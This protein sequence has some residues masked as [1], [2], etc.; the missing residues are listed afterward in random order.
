MFPWIVA[1][2]G[3]TNIRFGLVTAKDPETEEYEIL[4]LRDYVTAD[5]DS[6]AACLD[7]YLS[8]IRLSGGSNNRPQ[9]A[10]IAVAGPVDSDH[11]QLTNVDWSFSIAETRAQFS[12]NRLEVINDFTALACSVP[13]LNAKDCWQICPGEPREKA[14]KAIVGP[15]TGLG[16][17]ALVDNGNG[18]SPLP[19]EGGHRAY[20]PHTDREIEIYRILRKKTGYVCAEDLLSG[21]GL[22]NIY[23]SLAMIDGQECGDIHPSQI[24][25]SALGNYVDSVLPALAKETLDIFCSV[26]GSVCGDVALGYGAKGGV[27]LAGGILPRMK[28]YL[29]HSDFLNRFNTKGIISDY[30]EG[31]PVELIVHEKPALIGAAAWLDKYVADDKS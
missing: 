12:L 2:V 28:E 24:T 22:V 18:W 30:L 16:V 17:S 31:I 15:G 11:V 4:E 25:D 23:Q 21:V 3:G 13:Y 1:D 5:Y 19:S 6:F 7:V 29:L 10:C 26:L 20:S 14:P 8:S 9:S 27:Y